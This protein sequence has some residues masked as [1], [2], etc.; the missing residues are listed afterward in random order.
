MKDCKATSDGLTIA[1]SGRE[2]AVAELPPFD[3]AKVQSFPVS[4]NYASCR[5]ILGLL[6]IEW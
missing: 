4:Y 1:K 3:A 2:K 5:S 6:L